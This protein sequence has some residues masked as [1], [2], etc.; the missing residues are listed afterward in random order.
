[1]R[2]KIAVL[3]ATGSIG[4]QTLG[5]LADHPDRFELV[6]ATAHR[7]EDELRE[8]TAAFPAA[9][10]ALTG[11]ADDP[12]RAMLSLLEETEPDLV[13]NAVTGAAGLAANLW[14]VSEGRTLAIANKESLVMAGPLLLATAREKGAVVLPVDSEHSAIFQCC[15]AGSHDEIARL[16]LTASGGPFRGRTREQLECVTIQEALAH[17][18]WKMGPQITIDSA[19]LMNKALEIIEAHVL[20]GV[21]PE[22]IEVVVHP[23]SIVHSLV[24]FVDGSY[25]AHLGPPDMR[26]PIR[27]ALSYPERWE[28]PPRTFSLADL[29]AIHFESPDETTFSPLRLAREACVAGGTAPV[30]LNAANEVARSL[31]LD[32]Q[33]PFLAIFELLERA[34]VEHHV[35]PITD[36]EHILSV[37]CQTRKKISAWT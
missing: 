12:N 23:E 5:V 33:I 24:E 37:D 36:I 20:F 2:R 29:G 3:G 4:T 10:L 30:V 14:V 9:Q 31:F 11:A 27:Y 18:T 15:A 13:V 7:R 19:T 28:E 6:A 34:L 8:A 25:I 17:P 35:E 21:S 32:G 1:M 16:H 22:R 26:V